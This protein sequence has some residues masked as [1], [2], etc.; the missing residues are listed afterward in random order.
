MFNKSI[1]LIVL[2]V[3]IILF[4]PITKESYMGKYNNKRVLRRDAKAIEFKR[5][6]NG[7]DAS[8]LYM[9]IKN[10]SKKYTD[11]NVLMTELEGKGLLDGVDRE[12]VRT[13]FRNIIP[14]KPVKPNPPTNNNGPI[15]IQP[16]NGPTN[17]NGPNKLPTNNN[18]DANILPIMEDNKKTISDLEGF[19]I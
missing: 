6:M 18:G 13:F 2:L 1:V 12:T 17:N 16:I 14:N 4:V 11:V 7:V 3:V 10:I 9:L 15:T 8:K 5:L 19:N